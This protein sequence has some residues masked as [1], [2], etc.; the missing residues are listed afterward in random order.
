MSLT[1]AEQREL[2]ELRRLKAQPIPAVPAQS[3]SMSNFEMAGNA[4]WNF[5]SSA[6]ELGKSTFEAIT[7]PVQTGKAMVELGSSVLGK[8]G[9][10]DASPEMANR[11]GQF[12]KDRYGGVEN[13]RRTFATDPAGFLADA[14]TVLFAGGGT[15]R[16][17]PKA[18]GRTGGVVGKTGE[19]LT[20]VAG[21]IDPLAA[22]IKAPVKATT[23]TLGLTTGAGS[24]AIEEAAKAGYAGGKKGEAFVSQMRGTAPVN[25]VIDTIQPAIE[26]LRQQ[27]SE[28]YRQGMASIATDPTVL[29]FKP[30]REAMTKLREV[31]RFK[32]KE[33]NEPA[34]AAYNKLDEIL[35]D[36]EVSNPQDFHT[37]EGLDKLKQKI[38]NQSRSYAPGSPERMIADQLYGSVKS[39]IVK[40]AP[41][42]ADVMKDY[43]TASELL[44]EIET[45]LSQNRKASVDTKVRKLQSILR[46]NANTNYGRRVELGEMLAA[47][48]ADT[49]FPQLAGQALSAELPRGLS[50]NVFGAGAAY[51]TIPGVLAG[52][53]NPLAITSLALGSPRAIGETVFKA[54]QAAGTPAKLARL[55][56]QYGDAL[57]QINP[58]VAMKINRAKRDL[59][60]GK[61]LDPEVARNL[62]YQLGQFERATEEQEQSQ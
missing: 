46:N 39:Q 4:L 38:W 42:Y 13:A 23:Y 35:T 50:G 57:A 25:E 45:T 24:R 59:A 10:T 7:S 29:D 49:L 62:A 61:K 30:I 6:Y 28:T 22:A 1:P 43:E 41:K 20:E 36:W 58:S 48:G 32:G 51:S 33:I 52:A 2:E 9:I 56:A 55:L 21:K 44:R 53:T 19:R 37:P 40:Q 26:N 12:Y 18:M 60:Q 11:V 17:I 34:I 47:Q 14:S 31:G 16:A 54:G 27:R 5:P 15:L 3:Q 8:L